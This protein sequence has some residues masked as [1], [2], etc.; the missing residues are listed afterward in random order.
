MLIID[1]FVNYYCLNNSIFS[2]ISFSFLFNIILIQVT[3]QIHNL[4]RREIVFVCQL[5]Q[6]FVVVELCRNLFC[7]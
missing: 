1:Y 5:N 4:F 7:T 6:Q 2:Q 3:L